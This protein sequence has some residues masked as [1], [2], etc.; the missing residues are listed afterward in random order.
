MIDKSDSWGE[1]PQGPILLSTCLRYVVTDK[2]CTELV[3][4]VN[5]YKMINSIY[6]VQNGDANAKI[7]TTL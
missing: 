1:K 5:K 7:L 4:I 3:M 6:G 2:N